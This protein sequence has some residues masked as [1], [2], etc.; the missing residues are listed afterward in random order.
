[1]SG[2]LV[3]SW[4]LI[5]ACRI[6][7]YIYVCVYV[8]Y[9]CTTNSHLLSNAF[10][11]FSPL[12]HTNHHSPCPRLPPKLFYLSALRV[13]LSLLSSANCLLNPVRVLPQLSLPRFCESILPPLGSFLP[14]APP[15]PAWA[16]Q[17]WSSLCSPG[18]CWKEGVGEVAIGLRW[19]AGMDPCCMNGT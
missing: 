10:L 19:G 16:G 1:M 18:K 6:I 2:L 9:G 15:A 8:L 13:V 11:H 5:L 7:T 14:S 4:V 17:G 12:Y 3:H